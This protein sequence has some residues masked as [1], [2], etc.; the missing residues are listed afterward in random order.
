MFNWFKKK[1]NEP[2]TKLET[3]FPTAKEMLEKTAKNWPTKTSVEILAEIKQ[4]SAKGARYV[5]FFRAYISDQ[6]RKELLQQGYRIDISTLG[7]A[8]YFE[9]SW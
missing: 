6:T 9:V 8:P 1:N 2:E 3:I 7:E 4:E 5:C